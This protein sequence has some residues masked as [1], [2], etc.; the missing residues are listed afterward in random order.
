MTDDGPQQCGD[1]PMRIARDGTWYYHGTPIPRARMV[2]LFATALTRDD[3]GDYWL[4]TPGETMR[5]QVEDAP[6]L[7]V[8]LDAEGEGPAQ[9]LTFRTNVDDTV[10]LDNDH[11]L[12]IETDAATGEP[13][14]YVL[15]RPGLEARLVRSV[16]YSLMELGTV[17]STAAGEV[18]G[19][20]SNN[21]FFPIMQWSEA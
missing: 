13:S 11:P 12:R 21:R 20:W 19:V 1:F 7:A 14:P 4:V 6:F 18:F 8:D 9:R 3:A 17:D 5:I 2:S 15:V 16:F 10:P